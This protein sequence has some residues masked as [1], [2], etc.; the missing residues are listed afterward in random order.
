MVITYTLTRNGEFLARAGLWKELTGADLTSAKL[1]DANITRGD[2]Y[3]ASLTGAKLTRA[4]LT[5]GIA[6][7]RKDI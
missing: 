1:I 5:E 4:D 6:K 3:G 7:M 2:L